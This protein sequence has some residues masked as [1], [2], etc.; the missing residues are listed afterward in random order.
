MKCPY[1]GAPDSRVVD[2]RGFGG[3]VRRRRACITCGAR[4]TTSER[5]YNNPLYVVK[6]DGRR[7][8]YDR[9]KLASGI[10]TACEKRPLPTGSVEKIITGIDDHLHSLGKAEVPSSTIGDL[11]MDQLERVDHIA[12]IRFA[13]VYRE[14]TDIG[15]LREALESLSQEDED[16]AAGANEE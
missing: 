9:E 2:S 10:R 12:Y 16:I 7:E 13:S 4:F 5:V 11:V 1:C 3:E 6:K 15:A 14:F 8:A